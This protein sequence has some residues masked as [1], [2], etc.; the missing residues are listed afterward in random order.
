MDEAGLS[1]H[2]VAELKQMLRSQGLAVSGNKSLLVQRLRD[3]GNPASGVWD[4]VPDLSKA[5]DS[6]NA[7]HMS[8]EHDLESPLTFKQ[9][10][11]TTVYG[12]L[13]LGGLVAIGL[14]LIMVT[15]TIF[16]IQL[17]AKC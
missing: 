12:P 1:K 14:A 9:R 17:I 5:N 7:V 2:S 16:V 10:M 6:T 4:D 3:A 15:A 11:S 8:L 13:N